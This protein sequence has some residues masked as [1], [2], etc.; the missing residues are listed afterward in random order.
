MRFVWF[1]ARNRGMLCAAVIIV[2]V[3][4]TRLCRDEI[5][6][7]ALD[8]FEVGLVYTVSPS[9]GSYL[10]A[11]GCADAVLDEEVEDADEERRQ[12]RVNMKRWREVAADF[13][14]RGSWRESS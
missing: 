12:F 6:G 14:R 1:R 2:R 10:I 8:R 4:I 3:R 13:T 9:L 11:T 7:V 5:D